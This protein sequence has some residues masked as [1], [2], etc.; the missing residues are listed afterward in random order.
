MSKSNNTALFPTWLDRSGAS[1]LRKSFLQISNYPSACETSRMH[2]TS[3]Q[4]FSHNNDQR[5]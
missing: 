4:S 2:C 1:R 5:R 3:V